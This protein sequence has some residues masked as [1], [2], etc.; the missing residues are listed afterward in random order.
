VQ[1]V[2]GGTNA[3]LDWQ[4]PLTGTFVPEQEVWGVVQPEAPPFLVGTSPPEHVLGSALPPAQILPTGQGVHTVS[5]PAVT[6]LL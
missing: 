2:P 5:A 6:P 1:A 3:A 4:T